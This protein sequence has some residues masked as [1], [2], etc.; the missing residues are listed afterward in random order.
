MQTGWIQASPLVTRQL[1]WDPTCLPLSLSF[2]I[3]NKQNLQV[4][5]S[6]RQYNLF[7]ENYLA[8]KGLMYPQPLIHYTSFWCVPN[9]QY[10]IPPLNVSQPSYIIPRLNVSPTFHILYQNL[11]CPFLVTSLLNYTQPRFLLSNMTQT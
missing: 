1:A 10:I 3:K 9:L 2:P 11:I 6:R 7:L 5:E 4:L 8:F